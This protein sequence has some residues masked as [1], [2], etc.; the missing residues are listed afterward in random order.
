MSVENKFIS[1]IST[2]LKVIS[3]KIVFEFVCFA[4]DIDWM[5]EFDKITIPHAD[6]FVEDFYINK[7]VKEAN[8]K[9]NLAYKDCIRQSVVMLTFSEDIEII[10][11]EKDIKLQ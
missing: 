6:T 11:Y 3:Y 5:K 8:S 1:I 9:F 7:R 10:P 4:M 2:V